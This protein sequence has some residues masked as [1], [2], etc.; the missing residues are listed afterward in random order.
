MRKG[1]FL[2]DWLD[3]SIVRIIVAVVL[4]LA[5]VFGSVAFLKKDRDT[6]SVGQGLGAAVTAVQKDSPAQGIG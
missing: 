4:I 5:L 1:K 2:P 3:S 6:G